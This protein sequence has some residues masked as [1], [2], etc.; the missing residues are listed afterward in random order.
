MHYSARIILVS[1]DIARSDGFV[2]YFLRG[3]QLKKLA[4][5]VVDEG[6]AFFLSA[7]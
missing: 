2:D 6:Q 5:Y 4:H 1:V 7:H 3:C